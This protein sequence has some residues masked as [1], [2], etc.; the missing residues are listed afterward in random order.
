MLLEHILF[1]L[2]SLRAGWSS[3]TTLW[4]TDDQTEPAEEFFLSAP[5]RRDPADTKRFMSGWS[6]GTSGQ[7]LTA[8]ADLL[9][10]GQILLMKVDA[11]GAS[12]FL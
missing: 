5:T 1:S 9:L 4:A 7:P 10:V 8:V 12:P 2:F 3:P 6:P 11:E